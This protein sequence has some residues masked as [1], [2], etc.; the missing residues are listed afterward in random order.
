MITSGFALV[1]M[2][3]TFSLQ[4]ST[5]IQAAVVYDLAGSWNPPSNPNGGW[6]FLQGTTLLPYQT[7]IAALA[8]AGGYAPSP[9]YGSFLPCAWKGD[10]LV[11]EHSVDAANGYPAYGEMI[12]TWTATNSG[13]VDISGF[14]FYAHPQVSRANDF[15]IELGGT[16]LATGTVSY[17]HYYDQAH[18]FTF[19]TSH[20]AVKAGD[21]FSV[22]LSRSNGETL[23]TVTAMNWTITETMVVPELVISY[24]SNS[25]IVSWPNTGSY[26][27]QQN[28]NLA[29]ANDW[30]PTGY[31]INTANGTNS[32]NI[33][34]PAGNLFF[35]LSNP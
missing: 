7:S 8:G 3:A 25:V 35:R 23:G 27:L 24:S 1:T 10:G 6:S 20:L 9:N 12:T 29:L 17:T 11:A 22:T 5:Q 19:S 15:R 2:I 34:A 32:I 21:V 18:E 4:L 13:F 26:T 31:Q 30:V 16:L 33:T 28:A 14:M